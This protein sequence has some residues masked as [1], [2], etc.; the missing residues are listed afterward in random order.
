MQRKRLSV[1]LKIV[2]NQPLFH[3]DESNEYFLA[4]QCELGNS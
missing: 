4:T 2:L 3:R 1:N